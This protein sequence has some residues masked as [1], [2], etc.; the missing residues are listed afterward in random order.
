[1]SYRPS[2]P[3]HA[4]TARAGLTV[5]PSKEVLD[6]ESSVHTVPLARRR[7]RSHERPA[8]GNAPRCLAI[9]LGDHSDSGAISGRARVDRACREG[10]IQ[11]ARLD[12][13]NRSAVDPRRVGGPV[14]MKRVAVLVA[15]VAVMI[16][17]MVPAARAK[18][19]GVDAD[20]GHQVFNLN[21]I[22]APGDYEGGCGGGNRVFIERDGHSQIVWLG[23]DHFEVVWCDATGNDGPA[24]VDVDR[25]GGLAGDFAVYIRILGKLGGALDICVN[26]FPNVQATGVCELG[27]LHI[28]RDGGK[29]VFQISPKIWDPKYQ[30]ILW[31]LDAN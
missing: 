5:R 14:H 31:D 25:D 9:E 27:T 4:A 26:G 17:V 28:S 15:A 2:V 19:P 1:M 29:S 22:G 30:N 6:D 23:S 13:A 21:L 24:M 18:P 7:R 11:R 16:G 20:L 12:Q 8:V 10:T 3:R